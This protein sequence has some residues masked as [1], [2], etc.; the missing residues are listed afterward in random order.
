MYKKTT[1]ELLKEIRNLYGDMFDLSK[2]KWNGSKKTFIVT[3]LKHGD[4]SVR[5]DHFVTNKCGCKQCNIEKQKDDKWNNYMEKSKTIHN[6]KYIYHKEDFINGTSPTRITCPI[7][8]DFYMPMVRHIDLK[9]GCNKCYLE[10]KKGKY[11]HSLKEIVEKARSVHGEKYS[12]INY[13]GMGEK[14]DIICPIHGQFSQVA[15]DHLKGFGCEKCKFDK[16]TS[17]KEEFIEKIENKFPNKYD[18]SEVEYKNNHT[19]IKVGCKKHGFF[20]TTPSRLLMGSSCRKCNQSKLENEVMS[21]LEK[22]EID[23]IYQANSRYFPFLKRQS[24]DFYIPK[25]NVAIECQGEQHFEK[26]FFTKE[27]GLFEISLERDKRKRKLCDENNIK[28][29]Y[30]SHYNKPLY[31]CIDNIKELIEKIKC[32]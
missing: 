17:T 15:Y 22:N 16:Q 20:Y 25:Y 13:N 14:M 26:T 19:Y 12:Y 1:E 7:H 4:I 8:G 31:E 32:G 2:T 6:E 10:S 24:L 28:L 23:F 21:A 3:C 5:Y 9:Q 29:L 11:K 27:E 18:L 30:Y